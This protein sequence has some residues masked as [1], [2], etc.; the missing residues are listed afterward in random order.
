MPLLWYMIVSSRLPGCGSPRAMTK[1][2]FASIAR[3]SSR[4]RRDA[5]RPATVGLLV[6][7][8]RRLH[9]LNLSFLHEPVELLLI[10]LV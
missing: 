3:P 7:L 2:V 4:R 9:E 1:R 10:D 5:L 6:V 8:E